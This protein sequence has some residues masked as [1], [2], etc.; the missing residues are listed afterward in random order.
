ML[1]PE[2][3]F[4]ASAHEIC[5]QIDYAKLADKAGFKNAASA[6][7]TYGKAKRKLLG[8]LEQDITE[9][10]DFS[11]ATEPNDLKIDHSVKFPSVKKAT[12]EHKVTKRTAKSTGAKA[13][14]KA[15][16]LA[17]AVE[18]T[19]ANTDVPGKPDPE[20]EL[21]PERRGLQTKLK[22]ETDAEILVKYE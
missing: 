4:A 16:A 10:A 8:S 11:N 18:A 20:N 14:G 1:S 15:L 22:T 13:K 21:K 12:G 2:F 6:A 9:A 3:A 7:V 19:L 5:S 17:A